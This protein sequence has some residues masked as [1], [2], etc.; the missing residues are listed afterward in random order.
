MVDGFIVEKEMKR[1]KN[2]VKKRMLEESV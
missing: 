1:M 2:E